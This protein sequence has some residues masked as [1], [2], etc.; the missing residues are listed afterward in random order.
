MT[1]AMQQKT[2]SALHYRRRQTH[3]VSAGSPGGAG[4]F[5]FAENIPYTKERPGA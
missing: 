5:S 3:I 1:G 4:V 2:Y